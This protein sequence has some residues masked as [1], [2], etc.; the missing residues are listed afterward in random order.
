MIALQLIAISLVGA[1]LNRIRGGLRIPGTNI[2]FPLNKLWQPVFYGL[3][4]GVFCWYWNLGINCYLFGF[5]NALCMYIGQQVFG[6][7]NYVGEL[8]NG[9]KSERDE[10]EMIDELIVHISSPRVYGF[11]GL[12][13]RGL[14]WTFFLGLPLYNIPFMLS[15]A[16]MGVCY[17]LAELTMQAFKKDVGKNSWNLGEWYFGFV[18]W[19]SWAYFVLL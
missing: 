17:C 15:G 19:L 13:L 9:A 3:S 1:F 2:K 7:G 4:M 16:S 14:I 6:W 8:T 10:A 12:S 11:A 18:L 5:V